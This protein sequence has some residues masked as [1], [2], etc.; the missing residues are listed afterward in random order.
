MVKIKIVMINKLFLISFLFF[1]FIQNTTS[2]EKTS[3]EIKELIKFYKNDIRG[4]YHRIKW[5]C[6]D[7]SI[8][9]PKDPCPERIGGGIQHASFK[10]SA[11]KLRETNHLFFGE[12]LAAN[13]IDNFLDKKNNYSRIKQYQINNYLKSIDNGWIL[14][15]GQYYRGAIQSEDEEEWGKKFFQTI[16]QDN[17]LLKS[18][19]YLIRQ[20]L[21]DIPH[22]GDTNLNQKIRSDSKLL[23]DKNPDFMNIR[24]K[25]HGNPQKSDVKLVRDFLNNNNT[26]PPSERKDYEQLILTMEEFYN[27][28]ILENLKKE[29]SS[30]QKQTSFLNDINLISSKTDTNKLVNTIANIL[31]EIRINITNKISSEQRLNLLNNSNQLENIFLVKI[32]DWQPENISK[33]LDK[34]EVL[35]CAAHGTGLLETWEYNILEAQLTSFKTQPEITLKDLNNL[36]AISRNMVE[37]STALIKSNYNDEVLNYTNFEPLAYGFLDDRIRTSIAL[38]IGDTASKLGAFASKKSNLTNKVLEISNQSSFRGLNP[39][40]ALGKLVVVAGNS[41]DI[42]VENNKIY[43]FKNPPSDLKPVAGIMTVSEGNLVSH[44]QLLARNLGIPNSALSD[45]NLDELKK[46]HGKH[47]FY[48]VSNKGNIVMKLANDMTPLER[49]LFEKQEKE[50]SNNKITVPT[51]QIELFNTKVINMDKV[52]ASDSGKICG[53]KAANLGELKKMFPNEVVEGIIVPFGIFREH[54]NLQMP[55]TNKTYWQFLNDTFEEARKQKVANI[56]DEQIEKFTLTSLKRLHESILNINLKQSFINDLKDNFKSAFKNNIGNVPVFLRSDTNMEDLEEFTGAGL[57]LTLFNIKEEEKILNGIKKVWASAYTERSFKWRQ[58]YLLN[59]EN[60]FPSILIIP[61][62]DVD[63]SGVM[64]T[65]GI[66]VGNDNDL[67][68]AFSRGAGGAVDGQ[69]AETRLITK[70]DS[71]LL[72]PARQIDYIR[73]PFSGGT[74][75]YFTSFE[76]E[77][78]SKENI[79]DIRKIAKKIRE[80]MAKNKNEKNQIYDVEF[81]FKDDKLWLFQIRPFVENKQA[82]SSDYLNAI[83]PKTNDNIKISL[84]EKI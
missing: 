27:P 11:L 74:K 52:D 64:I 42:E 67:T 21:R 75:H 35:L 40:Y 19:Y 78:L 70:N 25:I 12:I 28:Q 51:N 55:N 8:R 43:I 60:V 77:I 17:N 57:N 73:L 23:A 66:N 48:A 37:W 2:Q 49:S 9:D 61:S 30:L 58:S 33:C 34:L 69:M 4:P 41:N 18:H 46:Y 47:I 63:Y 36:T 81:G 6:K 84:L 20:A 24:I 7:G 59:P 39:G 26:L 50:R 83:S 3:H 45:E 53:P 15:K 13:T 65:K 38:A 16:L 14:Q 82:N 68:V 22:N 44:V 1:L 79:E 54:M 31:H 10:E 5:F 76:K 29:L 62:V 72:S 80:K 56:S 71:K 32:Q